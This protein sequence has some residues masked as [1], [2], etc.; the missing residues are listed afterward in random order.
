MGNF[1]KFHI[2]YIMYV[3]ATSEFGESFDSI[4]LYWK[5]E[6]AVELYYKLSDISMKP[7]FNE[8]I[9]M[10]GE[11]YYRVNKSNKYI[12]EKH[13]EKAYIFEISFE[14]EEEVYIDKIILP[15]CPNTH[16]FGIALA[17]L[18]E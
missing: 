15:N 6:L 7:L 18:C 12:Y 3:L 13:L 17:N 14:F 11:T 10:K 4:K 16:I 5:D 8:K 2:Q 9:A 1:R